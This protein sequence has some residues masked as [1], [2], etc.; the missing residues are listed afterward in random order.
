MQEKK[1]ITLLVLN[2]YLKFDRKI[3]QLL[4]VSLGRPIKLKSILYFFLFAIIEATIYFTPIIGGILKIVPP[5][6]LLLIPFGMA[7]LLSD[8][9]TEGRNPI[10]F[11]RSIFLYQL[12]KRERVSYLRGREIARPATYRFSGYAT[13]EYSDIEEMQKQLK[14]EFAPNKKMDIKKKFKT[15]KPIKSQ[16]LKEKNKKIKIPKVK[17]ALDTTA[18]KTALKKKEDINVTHH[19]KETIIERTSI[20]N[21]S[22][23]Q[24]IAKVEPIVKAEPVAKVEPVVKAEPI[25]KVEPVVKAE[26]IAKVEPVVKAEPVAKVEPI[27]EAEPIAK[28]EPVAKVEPIVEAEPIAKVE[29]IVK[30]E[31]VAKVEPIVKAEKV[32]KAKNTIIKLPKIKQIFVTSRKKDTP[33]ID[34]TE[35]ER[36]NV[37]L[38]V[39]GTH[40]LVEKPLTEKEKMELEL[41]N[42]P[43]LKDL[44]AQ[45]K[46]EKRKM[47]MERKLDKLMKKGEW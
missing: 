32:E 18:I 41:A 43:N 25:A 42:R 14:Q 24:P 12:R 3:Y 46:E 38:P 6:F 35:I 29:P 15:E 44:R 19:E 28:V 2:D 22:V 4:G 36:E 30:A 13:V 26:P 17:E 34:E 16:K 37:N 11:F 33:T 20:S 39:Y 1:R 40:I 7:Y 47:K 31:P 5:V 10:A 21:E 23:L 27:V 8:I 45:V 9:R